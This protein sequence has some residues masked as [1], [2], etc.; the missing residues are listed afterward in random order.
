MNIQQLKSVLIKALLG[1]I[2]VAAAVAVVAILIGEMNST[3]ERSLGT[4]VSAVLHIVIVFIILSLST[5][6]NPTTKRSTE[7]V[8]SSSMLVAVLSFF[9]SV[10]AIW[11]LLGGELATKLYVSY[12]IILFAILH[13]KTL[14]DITAVYAKARPYVVANYVFIALVAA[15]LLRAVHIPSGFEMLS[16]FYGR[17][18]AA[19]AIVDVTLSITI[20]IIHRLYLQKHPELPTP[21]SN[22]DTNSVFRLILAVLLFIFF[23]CPMLSML[24]SIGQC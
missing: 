18:L 10:F 13:V 4:V 14:L 23:I 11:G 2:I 9:T 21:T 7:M 12:M 6:G 3:V 20:A 17:L 1:S 22:H 5:S 8:I 24:M 16:G 15:M 19:L